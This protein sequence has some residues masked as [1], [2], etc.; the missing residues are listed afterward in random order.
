MTVRARREVTRQE[1]D[2]AID[3]VTARRVGIDDPRLEALPAGAEH[4]IGVA[5]YVAAH[6]NVPPDVLAGDVVDAL[7]LIEYAR[8]NVPALPATLDRLETQLLRLGAAAGVPY[9]TM[10]R[11]LGVKTRQ[12][13]ENRLLR[14]AAT[15]HGQPRNDRA[16]RAALRMEAAD[17]SH[18][19]ARAAELLELVGQ[20]LAHRHSIDVEDPDDLTALAESARR[21]AGTSPHRPDY[22]ARVGYVASRV[23]LLQRTVT[24]PPGLEPVWVR[25]RA[26]LG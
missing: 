11:A 19:S 5:R 20:L 26:L 1:A 8:K 10:G 13:V 17:R 9:R 6:L 16:G 4:A 12:G 2:D 18:A 14:A 7:L 24:P 21:A 22:E 25:L 23:R 15:E 3:R